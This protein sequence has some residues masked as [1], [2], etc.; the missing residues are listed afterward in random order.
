[1]SIGFIPSV[2]PDNRQPGSSAGSIGYR[3]DSKLFI[4]DSAAVEYGEHYGCGDTIGCGFAL[5]SMEVFFTKNGQ[6][7]GKVTKPFIKVTPR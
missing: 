4:G 1:M 7:L 6:N 2:F 5:E 3:S